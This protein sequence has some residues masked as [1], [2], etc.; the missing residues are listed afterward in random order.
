METL[1]GEFGFVLMPTAGA[2]AECR[3]LAGQLLPENAEYTNQSGHIVLYAAEL[4]EVPLTLLETLL[5]T[6]KP[7]VGEEFT[8]EELSVRADHYLVYKAQ[9]NDWLPI[10]HKAALAVSEFISPEV[11]S[12][13]IEKGKDLSAAEQKNIELF[14]ESETLDHYE[15]FVTL[16]YASNL[17]AMRPVDSAFKTRVAS[18]NLARL[19][20]HAEL[21]EV[22]A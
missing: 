10:V 12:R 11:K 1:S 7:F 19:G 8:L 18:F 22:I 14:A 13:E 2:I 5:A 20:P 15:P 17:A 4:E 16:G 3:K 9:Q 21:E 6:M